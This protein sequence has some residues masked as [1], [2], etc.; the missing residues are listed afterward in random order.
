MLPFHQAVATDFEQV[1]QLIIDKLHS[2]VGLVENIGHYLV[3]AGGKR[4]RPLLVLLCANALGYKKEARLELAAIIEFIHTATLLHDDVVDVSA[5]RRGRP[6]ANAQW[7]NA[8]SVLVGDFLYS[9]AF[10][11]MVRIGNM[12][13]MGILADTT[14]TISEGE[15]QQLVNAKNP[16]ITEAD[17]YTVIHKKTAA[18]FEAACETA[19]VLAGAEPAL[20]QALRT[21]GYHL[22]L[23]F[24]LVDDA[25]DYQGD[26]ESLGKNVGDDLA[27]G[28]PTLPLLRAMQQGT[29]AQAALVAKALRE[30]DAS[31]LDA[32]VT[33]VEATGGATYT[34]DAARAQAQKAI[35]QLAEL[36]DSDYKKALISLANFS[37]DRD[38]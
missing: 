21:Y 38:H 2:N 19:A 35:A 36:P 11:M 28:K 6:T 16:A 20:R 4:L 34:L 22:G 26:A 13:V 32:V 9:R 37:V 12:D 10:Q 3:E 33:V 30:G 24:Q 31:Q 5:L 23:A 1:N 7:G 17:Y 27:E 8:P 14:N 29:E 25:L 15:V 18:L